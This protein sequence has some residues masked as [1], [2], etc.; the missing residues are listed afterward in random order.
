MM[1]LLIAAA[2][3]ASSATS[4]VQ[5]APAAAPATHAQH[6][7]QAQPGTKPQGEG[8]CCKK[9]AEGGKM[10]CCA[11]HGEGHGGEHAKVGATR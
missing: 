9:M 11:E 8:C 3:A 4:A 10:A 7:Q 5:P 6:G 1:T 2:L